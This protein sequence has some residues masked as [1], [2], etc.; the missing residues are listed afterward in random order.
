MDAARAE[1]GTPVSLGT[2]LL[3]VWAAGVVGIGLWLLWVNVRFARKLRLN[4]NPLKVRDCLL[5]VY[6][7]GMAQTPCLV[8]LFCPSI[9]VTEEVAADETVLRHSL[10]HE[11]TH[12]RHRDHIWAVLRGLCLALHW[13]N[14]LVWLAAVLSRRDGELCCDEATVKKLGEEERAAYGRTLLAVTCQGSVNPM[15]TATSMTGSGNGIRERIVLLTKRPKTAAYTLAAVVLITA[16]AVGCTFTGAQSAGKENVPVFSQTEEIAAVVLEGRQ[17][18]AEVGPEHL[19]EI[20]T[21]LRSFS[22]GE[23]LAEGTSL[24]PGADSFSVTVTYADGKTQHSGIDVTEWEGARYRVERDEL[25]ACWHEVWGGQQ[26]TE[27]TSADLDWDG[28]EEKIWLE[29]Q[30]EGYYELVVKEH[31]GTELF[32]EGAGMAHVG[33]NSLYLYRGDRNGDCLLRYNPYMSTGFASYGYTLFRLEGGEE[34]VVSE[35]NIDFEVRQV[36][37]RFDVLVTFADEVNT[38]LRRSALLLS[39]QD[40]ELVVGPEPVGIH[41]ERLSNLAGF[42]E[43]R[44][45]VFTYDGESYDLSERNENINA[46][47]GWALVGQYLVFEGHVGPN[48]SIYCIFDT[49]SKSFEPDIAGAHLIFCGDDIATGIYSFW[50]DVYAYDGTLLGSYELEES[51]FIYALR[52]SENASRVEVD[53]VSDTGD[54]RTE[55]IDLAA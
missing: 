32:R 9:Y 42:G 55:Y 10:A 52:Y 18:E 24:E 49:D 4:R 44:N 13:Y 48:N 39:T 14:P 12:F 54:H 43:E 16:A 7:T 28:E 23:A 33:W 30:L 38:L 2:V 50:S 35:G 27:L 29:E 5:P 17:S 8:G 41:L 6:I 31:D 45:T 37:D 21:W 26:A 1:T 51:E 34:Q 19:Q 47:A 20:A 36:P 11:L 40:G 46:I 22:L 25:P 15:L 53:I 3:G